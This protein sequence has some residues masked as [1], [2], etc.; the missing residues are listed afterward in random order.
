MMFFSDDKDHTIEALEAITNMQTLIS[1]AERSWQAELDDLKNAV[2]SLQSLIALRKVPGS[3]VDELRDRS[4]N[5]NRELRNALDPV[6]KAREW[7]HYLESAL[8]RLD[9]KDSPAPPL[10]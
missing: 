6:S 7:V 4:E 8:L 1:Q 5:I 9:S 3:T 2:K 10:Y